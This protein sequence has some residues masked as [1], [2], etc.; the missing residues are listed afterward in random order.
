VWTSGRCLSCR[1]VTVSAAAFALLTFTC[2]F[3]CALLGAY[4]R[5]RLPA[6]HLSKEAEDVVRLGMGLIAT[7]AEALRLSQELVK[8]R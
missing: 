6:P 3:G 8:V 4:V 7:K 2:T 5:D 1:V